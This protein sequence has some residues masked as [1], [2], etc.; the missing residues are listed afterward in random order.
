MGEAM[1]SAEDEFSLD[2]HVDTIPH[3]FKLIQQMMVAA[4]S[5]ALRAT[6]L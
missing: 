5:S 6:C 2:F 1:F 3:G 4:T